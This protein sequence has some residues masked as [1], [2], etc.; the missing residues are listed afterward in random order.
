MLNREPDSVR[1]D[2]GST[3]QIGVAAN[4]LEGEEPNTPPDDGYP[5]AD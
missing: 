5:F 1:G 4:F 3:E 2:E